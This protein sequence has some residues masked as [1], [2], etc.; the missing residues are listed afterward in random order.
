MSQ[1]VTNPT[2]KQRFA[3]IKDLVSKHRD[4]VASPQFQVA[5]D[6]ALLEYQRQLSMTPFENYNACAASHMRVVG[7]QE[8]LQQFRN[9]AETS[10]PAKREVAGNLDHKA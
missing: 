8:F 10:V 3:E 4:L 7:A 2:P 1:I 9:L 5:A 6:F